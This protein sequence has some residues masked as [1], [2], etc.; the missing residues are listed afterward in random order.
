MCSLFLL[1]L[2]CYLIY[3]LR[4]G[5]IIVAKTEKT[6]NGWKITFDSWQEIFDVSSEELI[7]DDDLR[8]KDRQD[9]MEWGY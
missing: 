2:G 4:V 6:E 3:R 8:R 7:V 5:E 1:Y 9:E